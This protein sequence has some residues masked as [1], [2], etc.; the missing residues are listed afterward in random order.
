[1]VPLRDRLRPLVLDAFTSLAAERGHATWRDAAQWLGERRVIS[2]QAPSEVRL[3]RM[4]TENLV[5]A[6][7]LVRVGSFKA[8]GARVWQAVYEPASSACTADELTAAATL[9]TAMQQWAR[10]R[11]GE[12][13]PPVE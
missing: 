7:Q 2:P 5:R 1:M 13:A 8:E 11:I 6:E 3:V 9:T 4:T 12:A 10:E